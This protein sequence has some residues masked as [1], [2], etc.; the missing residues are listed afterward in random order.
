MRCVCCVL[1]C[2]L[3]SRPSL[4][5]VFADTHLVDQDTSSHDVN[6]WIQT[7]RQYMGIK[8]TTGLP[9]GEGGDQALGGGG[10]GGRGSGSGS[11]A[12]QGN[13][14]RCGQAGHF[15]A[16]CPQGGGASSSS[17]S[18]SSSSGSGSNPGTGFQAPSAVPLRKGAG[19]GGS[20][21]AHA[22][23]ATR[24]PTAEEVQSGM[25]RMKPRPMAGTGGLTAIAAK[26]RKAK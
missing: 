11:G 17:S 22:A 21:M 13:C 5:C 4:P 16:A 10:G 19:V 12:L 18:S 2:C 6:P 20:M 23:T 9:K 15:A 3:T 25:V 1:C 7:E 26:L 8:K 14:F 24:V